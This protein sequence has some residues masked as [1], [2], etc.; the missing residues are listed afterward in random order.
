M[1]A[2]VHVHVVAL[3][4]MAKSAG[5]VYYDAV[6]WSSLLR[7][8]EDELMKQRD[9]IHHLEQLLDKRDDKIRILKRELSDSEK[10]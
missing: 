1:L 9:H 8:K 7:K 5:E 10:D 3:F 6:D 2:C 4:T